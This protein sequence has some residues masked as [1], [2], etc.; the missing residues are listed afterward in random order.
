M[1]FALEI[2]PQVR[3]IE[4]SAV[5]TLA[6]P[7]RRSI[8]RAPIFLRALAL[9][10][11]LSLMTAVVVAQGPGQQE[12]GPA[13]PINESDNPLLRPFVYRSIG[14]ATMSGRVD[15]I[16]ALESDPWTIYLG[17]AT[18]GVWKTTNNGTTWEPIFDT[19]PVASIGDLAISQR[20]P[21]IVWVG[22][23]EPNNR[24]SSS[25]GNGI[26][27]STDAGES[28]EHVGLEATQTI[29]RIVIHPDDDD[30]VWVAAP[31]HLFGA[32]PERG[33]F[34]TEDGGQ[35]WRKVL[36]VDED[37]G[38]TD[39]VIHPTDSDTLFA[40]TYQRRRTSWGMNGG[41]PGSG[42]WKSTDGGESWQQLEGNGLPEGILG[43]IGLAVS[44]SVPD[45][46]YAQIE[47]APTE[48][49]S[50]ERGGQQQQPGEP[51]PPPDP[52]RSGVWRSDDGG[53]SWRIMS[54][55][56]NR[57]MYY[58]QIRVDPE[59]DQIVYTHGAP[60][61][62][63]LDGGATFE[64]LT[65]MGHG[66]HHALWINPRDGRHLLLGTDGGFNIS[67]DRGATWDFINIM[68]VGQFYAI[69]ADMRRPYWVYGGLQDNGSWGAPS[70]VRSSSGILN[71]DWFRVG[72]GD[73]FYTEIDPTAPDVLY[74]ESQNGNIRRL[75]L[76]TG[77]TTRI[78]PVSRASEEE[79]AEAEERALRAGREIGPNVSNIVPE[80]AVDTSY[81]WNWNTPIHISPHNPR[82][83]YVGAN[84]FFKSVDRGDTWMASEDLTRQIDR[85]TLEIMRV[86]GDQP[87]ASKNDGTSRYGTITTLAESPKMPG[88]IWV[89]T[90]DGT[91]QVSRDGGT[92]WTNLSDNVP[93]LTWKHQISRVEPSH[94][95][96]ATCYLTI[97]GHRAD[98]M[99]PYVFV[100]RD[101]GETWQALATGLPDGHVNVVR[102]DPRNPDLLYLGTEH[103]LYISLDGG[104]EWE[105]FMNGLPTVRID[106]LLIHP[107]E[108]DL[109]VGTHGRSIWI[110]DDITPLQQLSEEVLQSDVHLFD[111]R[112]AVLWKTDITEARRAGGSR[113]FSGQNPEPGTAIHYYLRSEPAGDVS[114]LVTDINGEVVRTLEPT[115]DAGINRV[116]WNLLQDPPPLPPEMEEEMRESGAS[117]DE[118]EGPPVDPGSYF[119]TLT[120]N[121]QELRTIVVVEEDV[122][123]DQ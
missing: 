30:V 79:R 1:D 22:T 98:D 70:M 51:P 92:S 85:E 37:T 80:P 20:D 105:R 107:R 97:D 2:S 104:G 54:N 42:I 28:F 65:G 32:N 24:Q 55:N 33:V 21:S 106:D 113:R 69:G 53:A 27:K 14:P 117:L 62:Q 90:D 95:D 68:A 122:W 36:F 112:P 57:P 64:R 5:K 49:S 93:G 76:G 46:V 82:T 25:Y 123:M 3:K 86:R 101:Y 77:E 9:A 67:Y 7:A 88:V 96:A 44:R 31:G 48:E 60:F 50:G 83:I 116:Q 45:V 73:G 26:Y 12:A 108:N 61:Y 19:Y 13:P 119:V 99:N 23:G 72:G 56:N 109:I 87:M 114:L 35:S 39:I 11:C 100:T 8:M 111:V 16:E 40:A 43:R 52:Q 15:D 118:R 91:L 41:G 120:V 34:K 6:T 103:A 29:A 78:R 63:S 38:A 94:F 71:E 89:G 110:I 17:L 47:V 102:E 74:V 18:G 81:S 59:N 4:S 75:D 10:L 58:S 121:G 84:V 115:L 66:D